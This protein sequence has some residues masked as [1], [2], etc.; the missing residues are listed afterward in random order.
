MVDALRVT[1]L[2]QGLSPELW[3]TFAVNDHCRS[4]A[5]AREVLLFDRLVVPVPADDAERLRWRH[6]LENAPDKSW[7]P[8]RQE[9]LL[10]LLGTQ[11][12]KGR[13]GARLVWSAPWDQARWDFERSRS[14]V[15]ETISR[16]DAFYTTRMILAMEEPLPGVI[17]AAAAYPSQIACQNELNPRAEP[18]PGW[19]TAAEALVILAAPLLVPAGEE[20]KDFGPLRAAIDLASDPF[21]VQQRH[22]YHDWMR[23]FAAKLRT[24]GQELGQVSLDPASLALAKERLGELLAAQHA[25]LGKEAMAKRW[26]KIEWAAMVI[27]VGATI[28]VAVT[29]PLAPIAIAGG[30]IGFGG[31][32]AGK[33]ASP[34]E[35][36]P[37]SSLGGASMFLAAQKRL[38]WQQAT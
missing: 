10:T 31:W 35:P 33:R 30:L 16:F 38:D 18:S 1:Q 25:L 19:V 24:E 3:G 4:N 12:Q 32:V 8:D 27:S 2:I 9:R 13:N 21:F 14:E 15:A 11:N 5:F 22:L 20:G 28:A 17:E 7:D 6:P 36:L 29:S 23:S 26:K 37:P 34:G